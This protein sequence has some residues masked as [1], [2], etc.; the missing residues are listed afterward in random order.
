MSAYIFNNISDERKFRRLQLVKT[1]E[2]P[3]IIASGEKPTIQS[4][5][6]CQRLGE[7]GGLWS[8]IEKGMPLR[9]WPHN[10]LG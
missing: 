10:A 5:R 8:R 6:P 2:D 9:E 7:G 1:A 3:T 4:H